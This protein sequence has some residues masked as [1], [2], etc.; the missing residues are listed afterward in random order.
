MDVKRPF[1]EFPVHL[2][3]KEKPAVVANDSETRD[4]ALA[5]GFSTEY[6]PQEY[7]KMVHGEVNDLKEQAAAAADGFFYSGPVD[8][9]FPHTVSKTIKCAEEDKSA[10]KAAEAPAAPMPETAS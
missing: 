6:Q 9:P 1:H 3:H 5:D 7:P 4:K 8:A 10:K 2:Y